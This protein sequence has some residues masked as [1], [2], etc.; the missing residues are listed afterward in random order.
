MYRRT[1]VRLLFPLLCLAAAP[2]LAAPAPAGA[3][4]ATVITVTADHSSALSPPHG[5]RAQVIYSGNVVIHRGPLT[6]LG[7]RAVI[8]TRKQKIERVVV[9]GSPARFT[10]KP[11]GRPVIHG[12]A[13]TITYTADNE[14]LTLDGGVHLTRPGESFSAEHAT[15]AL[16]THRL[17]AGG[18]GT[19][20]IHAVLT[21]AGGSRR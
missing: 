14:T 4:P 2:A 7:A 8:H 10:M 12:E 9:T 3:S 18:T 13:A 17:E 20:R 1:V 11:E 16:K 15:Y 21:P 5:D 6:L 19:G